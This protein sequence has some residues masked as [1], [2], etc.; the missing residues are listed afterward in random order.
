MTIEPETTETA[1][2]GIVPARSN[3]LRGAAAADV[4]AENLL[5][6]DLTSATSP[7]LIEA[8]GVEA[9]AIQ[10]AVA[11]GLL[12]P[13]DG[14]EGVY[15]LNPDWFTDPVG[16]TGQGMSEN[17]V[18]LAL[19]IAQLIGQASG[20]SLGIPVREP[21]AL[22]TWYPINKPGTDTP[23][24]LYL[25]TQPV[26]SDSNGSGEP[27]TVFGLGVMYTTT[28]TLGT[29]EKAELDL[30][31]DGPSSIDL[32]VWG[33]VPVALL[34]NGGVE[35][36][37]GQAGHPFTMGFEVTGGDGPL[38]D[39]AGF[40]FTG[41]RL[42]V[43]LSPA[44]DPAVTVSLVITQLTLPTAPGARD[45]TLADLQA[46][47]GAE[48]LATAAALAV[49]A[50][51]KLVGDQP[52][53][54]YLLPALG[55]GASVP[56]VDGVL[57]PIL[58]WDSFIA[59]AVSG[60][61]VARPFVDW[62]TALATD[63]PTLSAW[64][65]AVG[66]AVGGLTGTDATVSGSGTRDDPFA[67]PV[68]SV[69]SVGTLRLTAGSGTDTAGLRHFYPGLAFAS[70]ALVLGSSS[71]AVTG[72][73]G[74]EILD[75]TLA[76]GG[77]VQGVAPGRFKAGILLANKD[78]AQPL[79]SGTIL[80]GTYSF[81]ALAGGMSVIVAD[82]G[83]TVQPA[84]SLLSV[85]TPTGSYPTIDLT[86]PGDLVAAAEAE[87]NAAI[88]DAFNALFGL[89]T[90][91]EVGP[92]LAALLGVAPPPGATAWPSSLTPPFSLSGLPN[93]IQ[94]PVEALSRY[95]A[96]LIRGD[97]QVDGQPP[98]YFMVD[99]L[100]T[101]LRQVGG[102]S[103]GVTGSGT[104]GDPWSMI[105][106]PAGSPAA[107]VAYIADAQTSNGAA[108]RLVLGLGVGATLPIA[109]NTL[110]L[111]FRI[112]ALGLDAGAAA[113]QG[114]QSAQILPG[115]GVYGG[116][117]SGVSTPAVAGASL[118]IDKGGL[119][120]YWSP[121]D[122]WHW[123]MSV[124]APTLVVD[125]VPEPVGTDMNYSDAT[126]L[127]QLVTDQAATFGAILTG[128]LGVALYRAQRRGGLA[129]DGWLGLLPNLGPFMPQGIDWP[130]GMPVLAPTSFTD[131][132]GQVR[133]Q[134]KSVLSTPDRAAA[135]LGL[136]GW[137]IDGT[138]ET[139]APVAGTGTQLDPYRV[140][141]DVPWNLQGTLWQDSGQT[142]AVPGL[143]TLLSYT[144]GDVTAVTSVRLDPMG[145]S[146]ST[147]EPVAA[148][149]VPGL[150]VQTVLSGTGG[151]LVTVDGVAV[152]SVTLG[153]V[154]TMDL[155]GG[156][157]GFAATPVLAA[158]QTDGTVIVLDGT[159]DP[160]ANSA[161]LSIVNAA[162][163][164]AAAAF[165]GDDTFQLVYGVLADLGLA[166]PAASADGPYG[167]DPGGFTALVSS[168][169]G[170]LTD[171]LMAALA[172]A[173]VQPLL[174]QAIDATL[175]F[176]LPAMPEPLLAML[177]G[178][179]LVTDADHGYAA[180][181][182]AIL[183]VAR[184]PATELS[185]RLTALL[186]DP[187]ARSSVIAAMTHGS[188]SF[189][190]GPCTLTTANGRIMTLTLP[191]GGFT[192]G[193]FLDP[194][195]TV[196]VDL[197]TGTIT[198][199]LDCFLPDAGFSVLSTL[200]YTVGGNAPTVTAP[201]VTVSLVWGDGSVPQPTPLVIWPF[202]QSAFIDQLAAVGPAYVLATFV[203]EAVDDMLLA[204]YP[205]ARSLFQAF[206][207]ADPDPDT[208]VW[209]MKSA[210][211]LFE[212]PV[213]WLLSD[214]VVGQDGLLNIAQIQ[215]VLGSLPSGSAGGLTLAQAPGG[216][217]LSGLPYGLQ[218]TVTAD[219]ATGL[220]T[221]APALSEAMPLL[222]GAE[223]Q[224]MGFGLSL[225]ANYQ[226][227][228]SG[229]GRLTAAI[230]GLD[231]P[232][233][234]Q[235]GY[236]KGFTLTV[237]EEGDGKPVLDLV[238][239][240]GW[241]TFVLQ[242]AAEVAQTLLQ[243][244]TQKLLDQLAAEGDTT[245]TQFVTALRSTAASLDINGLV[246]SL[247]AAQPDAAALEA[248]AL[249]WLRERLQPEQAAATASAVA[250][251]LQLALSGVSSDGGL[252]VY[253]PSKSVP[254][255]VMAGVR[256]VGA[257][258]L[259]GIWATLSVTAADSVVV[260]L[261]PTGVGVPL[262]GTPEARVQ[263]GLS[264]QAIIALGQG[265]GLT[266]TYDSAGGVV[267]AAVDP[268]M[269]AGVSSSLNAEL[270]PLPF[271]V[272]TGD[273]YAGR[274]EA[275]LAV[276]LE[277]V[278]VQALP[279]YVSVVVL[280][281]QT[282]VS[283][284]NAPLFTGSTLTAGQVLTASQLLVTESGAY[285]LNDLA[286]LQSLGV[287]GFL[288]GF[289]KALTQTQIQVLS[290]PDGGGIWLEPGPDGSYGVRFAA[291]GLSLKQ[292]PYLVFQLGATDT[293]WIALTGADPSQYQPGV[294]A[295]LPVDGLIPDFTAVKL[296]L[297]N[298]G[299]DFQ[300]KAGTPL[301]DFSRFQ[302]AKIKPR[303]LL[304][305]DFAQSDPITAYGGGVDVEDIA[306][307]LAPDTLT[308]GANTN[309]VA[310]NLLGSGDTTSAGNP[311]ANPGFSMRA[312]WMSGEDLGV[313][314]YD[315]N[316]GSQ[317]RIWLP[318]QRSFGPVHANKV[319]IGWDNPT[320]IGSVLFD[321]GL[322]LAGLDVELIDLS[323]S[324]NVTQI[325]DYSQYSLDLAGLS[326]SFSG[327]SVSVSGGL[328]KQNNPL[329]YDGQLLVKAGSFSLYAVGSF[330]LIPVDPDRPDGDK[331]VSFFVFL[332]LNAP[333]GGVPAFFVN[334]VAGG[335][336]VNRNIIVPDAGNIMSFPL[337]QGAISQATFGSDPTPASALAVLS[338]DV[339]P[340]IG[341]Y[342]V[343][344]GLK[345]SS[346]QILDV[347]AMLLVKF[348]R[349][350]EIDV[351]GVATA[352]LPPQVSPSAA[353]A[354]IEL[355]LVASFKP[356][357]GE[358]SVT[359]QLTPSSF[360]LA[361][362]CKLT[363]GFA[364]KFWF[365]SNPYAGD[366]VIT[367]G[368]YNPSFQPPDH[369]PNVPRLGF[370][371]P[372]LSSSAMTVGV[373][374]GTYFAL[375]PSM[376][377]AGGYLKALFKAGPLKAWFNA[378]ADFLIAWQPFY[379]YAGVQVS[380]G[381][382]FGFEVAGVKVTLTAELGAGLELWGPPTAGKVKVSWYVISFT[383]PFG[384]QGQ[385]LSSTQPLSWEE[386]EARMLPQPDSQTAPLA[387]A[388]TASMMLAA[389]EGDGTSSGNTD[390]ADATQVVVNIQV[391][392]GLLSDTGEFGPTVQS[393][394]FAIDL[395]SVMPASTVTVAESSYQASSPSLGIP[396]MDLPD[397][398]TAMAVT[399]ESQDDQGAW[400]TLSI[401]RPGLTPATLS[402][403]AAAAMWSTQAFDP[404]G[405]PSSDFI[406][407]A[408]FGMTLA[409]TGDHVV[410]TLAPM[411][412]LTSFGYEQADPLPLPFA[413]TPVYTAPAALSQDGRFAVLM[414]SIMAPTPSTLR[415]QVM[416]ALE[417]AQVAVIVDQNLSV[418]ASFA[419]QIFQAA[420]SLAK[421]GFD[422]AT[423]GPQALTAPQPKRAARVAAVEGPL[424]PRLLGSLQAYALP[425][426]APRRI[427]MAGAAARK[428]S[429]L[430]PAPRV[431]MRWADADVRPTRGGARTLAGAGSAPSAIEAGL[432]LQ[433]GSVAVFDAGRGA[434]VP[435]L[436]LTGGTPVMVHAFDKAGRILSSRLV[437]PAGSTAEPLPA[438]TAQVT[439][440][441]V[442]SAGTAPVAGW[443]RHSTLVQADRYTLLGSGCTVRPQAGP[444]PQRGQRDAAP[445]AARGPVEG[446]A[447]LTRNRV[448]TGVGSTA[449]GWVETVFGHTVG[450]VAVVLD[451]RADADA[452]TVKIA[453]T[454]SPWTVEYGV[455]A[456]PAARIAAGDG[457]I[458]LYDAAALAA[459]GTAEAAGDGER[460]AVLVRGVEGLAGVYGLAGTPAEVEAGW[461]GLS[462]PALG[463][464]VAPRSA[465]GQ[466]LGRAGA[467]K[468]GGPTL[469]RFVRSEA[470]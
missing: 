315:S 170:F 452:V 302:L 274:L 16:K 360:L 166:V 235:G 238:P 66:G 259:A 363:G 298:I 43:D 123:S 38:I 245:L 449:P 9:P 309:P 92:S 335:F 51:G 208:G 69:S 300:G 243:T 53:L 1:R 13:V 348:G 190:V 31:A 417:D 222:A 447:M 106:G 33:M 391:S 18:T 424:A 389:A 327:G 56:G 280:N 200:T 313:E 3:A 5:A 26:S 206:G 102:G 187:D 388:R 217:L 265:P 353:L 466:G 120:L 160:S 80:G 213:D 168:P 469:L 318:V 271:G 436:E 181:A 224:S 174:F 126:G 64:M 241:Q 15:Q 372:V 332:N 393:A 252:L 316:G 255:T 99:A 418:M 93:S 232:L 211:G 270:L 104:G 281:T 130:D 186:S 426:A 194:S 347:F 97:V 147:G 189:T 263:F 470:A 27:P 128:V 439:L 7:I 8:A 157:A 49:T 145:I 409:A 248:A 260:A 173:T 446:A 35:V 23:S 176:S 396:P 364:A 275:A 61:D 291:T 290:F 44:T 337:I 410:D 84:F 458:L 169:L 246:Q 254:V 221:V 226:P 434:G 199:T 198:A 379:Y 185:Q 264:A 98:F 109:G 317:T 73:A 144:A 405:K 201:T 67:V 134:L 171:R 430:L 60:G 352:T 356:D 212:K 95:W 440:V 143:S 304:T 86:Q 178:L 380:V 308:P 90:D 375:T 105:L 399:L 233:F 216:V 384:D 267:A 162:I 50:L 12:L 349:E 197:Q 445:I 344:A 381:V 357:E 112:E 45:F 2:T 256:T 355:A 444:R 329:R 301:V 460:H 268:L 219:P 129:L 257:E 442:D 154:L 231:Q 159:L 40:S 407:G 192:V 14:Q 408:A 227:G 350:F 377:M 244:L 124:A 89:G 117:P 351:I 249:A 11:C 161:L 22:G 314:L 450:T 432:S 83:A 312:G 135:V 103:G 247:I 138:D 204:K 59:L 75:F 96:A 108:K 28:V 462:L 461:D 225:T 415:S 54:S 78:I 303:G 234:L 131:P 386:F 110:D 242:V 116:L 58:R 307:S 127:S 358:I 448:Q 346:F 387:N 342:W 82:G 209:Q 236:D 153:V 402:G 330:A 139:A 311:A 451:R 52:S 276:W 367:L 299:V 419:D 140:P 30:V 416:Q 239:F 164:V 266:V 401:D 63:G 285:A 428:G 71:A 125:G 142:M 228:L 119:S 431:T 70:T 155:S 463:R 88:G 237:G 326:V 188:Q 328:L 362:D 305:F 180:N 414:G 390:G 261:T 306:I 136:L 336:S 184:A 196:R 113:G 74:L 289:L 369:Y 151:T 406:A 427:Q 132:I 262:T 400:S 183:A 459:T 65:K 359:A 278:M 365:G 229:S 146:W 36:V 4:L 46:I 382:S 150:S 230:P 122:G 20:S 158:K 107:L 425:A 421:L 341:S 42:T 338:Q 85:T 433:P 277:G 287:E 210:L 79:Y 345:F 297:I 331:A 354:Y 404:V 403:G 41:V 203:A 94:F 29:D 429:V 195:L 250:S 57:L 366:F 10:L 392:S 24:G 100:G 378:G 376:I 423:S 296:R 385:D 258:T 456:T 253:A 48:I 279:R 368:G 77:G 68:L 207:L 323:V 284:L 467:A 218:V 334:G 282:V 87:L 193:S 422:L 272:A 340:Q 165:K 412:L 115:I 6:V 133:A 398:T 294:A 118:Q 148:S 443:N 438:D 454:G 55:L 322:T 437:S 413:V 37:V 223:L 62:F 47:S 175:G 273:G 324:V 191:R 32:K 395:R 39:A 76:T 101:V 295:Y 111:A 319:G 179:G 370:D 320:K 19:V 205:L 220:F 182:E 163:G 21:G 457:T 397:I 269:T 34:G 141:L 383:I 288:A 114:I 72:S 17:A 465:L 455:A 394:P 121:Y 373:S 251:L 339:Y 325:T 137:A 464:S 374:G 156:T 240:G 202:D 177:A 321:G 343:A 81:G 441:G 453:A 333:L 172:D 25:A 468:A 435:M 286:S 292:V 152:E 310:Q 214:A 215:K 167:I 411:D 361:K 293:E 371:W 420:P 91:S 149:G 283:W